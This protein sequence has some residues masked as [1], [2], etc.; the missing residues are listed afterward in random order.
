[1]VGKPTK[2]KHTNRGDIMNQATFEDA[3]TKLKARKDHDGVQ[4]RKRYR[5]NDNMYVV[6]IFGNL[7]RLEQIL[8]HLFPHGN[9]WERCGTTDGFIIMHVPVER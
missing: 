3:R 7:E 5:S 4:F 1:M 2:Y 6:N 8:S 9:I